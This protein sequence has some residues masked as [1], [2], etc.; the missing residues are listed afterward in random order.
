MIVK[1]DEISAV[2]ELNAIL[3]AAGSDDELK[4]EGV[5]FVVNDQSYECVKNKED[6][7]LIQPI[8]T[9]E[10]SFLPDWMFLVDKDVHGKKIPVMAGCKGGDWFSL[11]ES[12]HIWI[13]VHCIYVT[14]EDGIFAINQTD[15]V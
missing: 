3:E 6:R 13:Q 15:L 4:E 7:M 12:I 9:S 14:S 2:K 10:S 1:T 5:T 11:P 8:H